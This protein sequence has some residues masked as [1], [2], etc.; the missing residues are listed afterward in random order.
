MGNGGWYGTEE[1]WKRIESPLIEID[2]IIDE[3]A[4]EEGLRVTKN[5]KDWPERS[6][7]WRDTRDTIDCLLQI[8][9]GVR[10]P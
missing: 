10:V 2:P 7:R 5:L 4:R 9:W 8:Y 3:F 1:E 6:L